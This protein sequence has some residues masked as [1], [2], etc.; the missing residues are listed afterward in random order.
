MAN[1]YEGGPLFVSTA[2]TPRGGVSDDTTSPFAMDEL[3]R[4]LLSY[5]S[6]YEETNSNGTLPES[7]LLHSCSTVPDCIGEESGEQQMTEIFPDMNQEDSSDDDE[8][9]EPA[10]HWAPVVSRRT[11]RG[12][13]AGTASGG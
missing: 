10:P 1:G 2:S 3:H 6:P 11:L 9:D 7:N 13:R 8:C 12:P 4:F 5:S